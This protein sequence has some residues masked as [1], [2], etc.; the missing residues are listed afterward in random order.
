MALSSR[1]QSNA[2][3][4]SIPWR[5]AKSHTYDAHTNPNGLISFATAENWLVQKELHDYATKIQIP[6]AAFRYAFSTGGGPRLPSAFAKHINECFEPYWQV[7]G[8]DIMI[9]AA[10]T[11]MHEVLGY[12]LCAAGEGILT[13][14]P[15]YGRFEI[16]FGNK[17]G[18][19]L[20]AADTDHED[21]FQ[22][23]VV[24]AFEKALRE[25]EKAGVKVRAVLVI[26]PHNPLGQC[27]T[28]GSAFRKYDD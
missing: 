25:S 16:D 21:C 13:S 11:S 5:F 22:E 18:V 19:E 6:R 7:E 12:S 15:Y 20:V 14:R 9:T 26:N 27:K 8:G 17:V 1:G 10:A 28:I 2:S 4:L 24:D 23:G 3:Q